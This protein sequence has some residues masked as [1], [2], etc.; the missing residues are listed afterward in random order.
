MGL[1]L[2]GID[3]CPKSLIPSIVWIRKGGRAISR[4]TLL[5]LPIPEDLS[6]YVRAV[7]LFYS[8]SLQLIGMSHEGDQSDNALNP[9]LVLDGCA[10]L[11]TFFVVYQTCLVWPYR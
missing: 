5:L 8:P 1:D 9:L 10:I 3:Y 4:V 2:K 6:M 7:V 11:R